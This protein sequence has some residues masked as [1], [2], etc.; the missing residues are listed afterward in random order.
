M[1]LLRLCADTQGRTARSIHE[2]RRE[3]GLGNGHATRLGPRTGT[4]RNRASRTVTS[5]GALPSARPLPTPAIVLTVPVG[6]QETGSH[7]TC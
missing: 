3:A 4:R 5:G 7:G 6:P 1:G 2:V